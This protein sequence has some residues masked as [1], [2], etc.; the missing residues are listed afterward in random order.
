MAVVV[1][2]AILVIWAMYVAA[3][4]SDHI[5]RRRMVRRRLSRRRLTS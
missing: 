4:I 5:A 2:L 1:S 3:I